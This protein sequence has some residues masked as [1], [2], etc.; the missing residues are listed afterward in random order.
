VTEAIAQDEVDRF[1][2][3]ANAGLK[4]HLTL[5]SLARHVIHTAVFNKLRT[6][7]NKAELHIM[8]STLSG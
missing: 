1:A 2:F 3:I 6:R 7:L 5:H 4:S 8:R